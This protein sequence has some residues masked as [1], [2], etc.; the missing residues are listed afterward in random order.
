MRIALVSPT[1]VP[2]TYGGMDR[3]LEGLSSALRERHPTD[4]I[5]LP[6][7]ERSREGVLRGYY[8]FYNLDLGAYD[9]VI[10]YKAPAYM[11]RHPNQVCYLSHR[12]RVFYDLY[13]PADEAHERMRDVIH[14]LDNWALDKKR[15]PHLFTVGETVTRRLVR[16]GNIAS[17]PLHHPTTFQP[18]EWH[19]G[20][21]FLSVGRL[22][23]WK[24][25]DLIIRAFMKTR[26]DCP[27]KIVGEGPQESALRELAQGDPRIEFV[28]SVSDSRLA[29]LY[30]R[31][32]ATVFPPIQ[33]DMGLITFESFLSGKPLLT[34]NDSGEPS[35][36]VEEGK[37]GFVTEATPDAMGER[38]EWMWA[39][40]EQVDAMGEACRT[41]MNPVTWDRLVSALLAAGDQIES[42]RVT[43]AA[44]SENYYSANG[45]NGAGAPRP[46]HL[47]VTDN[48]IIDPPVGGGRI[49]ILELY[50]HLPGDFTTTYV[51]AFDYPGPIY[52]DQKLFGNFREILTPLTTPHFKAHHVLARLTRNDATI[53]VTMPLLGRWTPRYRRLLDQH[54]REA[55]VLIC[56]HPWMFPFLPPTDRPKVYDSQNCEA[57]VK[58]GLLSRTLAG[59]YLAGRVKSTERLAV[60]QSNLTLACSDEDAQAFI[61]LYGAD[62]DRIIDVPNGVDC[63][64]I[65]PADE[66][67]KSE[68]RDKL[69]ITAETFAVFTG[70]NYIPN[71]EAAEFIIEQLAPAFPEVLFGLVGGV[72]P[73]YRE[74][75]PN[76]PIPSNVRL[77]GFV[78]SH[79]LLSVYRAADVALN[80]MLQGSGTN[81]KM[82][83]YLAAGLP[84]VTTAKGSRGL[85]GTAGDDWI[86]CPV[87]NFVPEL[88][89]LLAAPERRSSLSLTGR[90][91]A[92]SSYDWAQIAGR[93]AEKLRALVANPAQIR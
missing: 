56:A 82:L 38:I 14:W 77:F 61:N 63:R 37:T 54:I 16:F 24:R 85:K 28:G 93:L 30:S 90:R 68:S 22:H 19:P 50:R 20:E 60:E 49:R 31:A 58:G 35:L 84:I 53:D 36:I 12:M 29:E 70:S 55:D 41:W 48:Q 80:P 92:E 87:E 3:L 52:R 18:A 72:G 89:Q 71:L 46:I 7:D 13:E 27:L 69:G 86:E 4:L 9:R 81:I 65:E 45:T 59:R 91:L 1:P 21:Y 57:L 23:P 75:N 15:V 79:E 51:G 2:P 62:P 74:R 40:R 43:V 83:D 8:D 17:T 32:L 5:T 67:V 34:T 76:R 26:A 11:V 39:H 33:E 64:A 44:P 73:M 47:L 78:E 6:C 25:V 66:R 88:R 42:Q 10:T